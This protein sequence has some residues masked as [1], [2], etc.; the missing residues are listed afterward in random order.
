MRLGIFAC[1]P[2]LV[3][4]IA[5]KV[6]KVSF[7]GRVVEDFVDSSSAPVGL[8]DEAITEVVF[9]LE[10]E[11]NAKPVEGAAEAKHFLEL[12]DALGAADHF[13]AGEVNA[14][15]RVVF[16]GIA[17]VEPGVRE[18]DAVGEQVFQVALNYC[19]DFRQPAIIGKV[20][21]ESTEIRKFLPKVA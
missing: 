8:E 1:L 2:N 10:M 4:V 16:D 21:A 17:D 3:K 19:S 12:G 5:A 9:C 11:T 15:T 18:G 13:I 6:P 7:D 14:V 20:G